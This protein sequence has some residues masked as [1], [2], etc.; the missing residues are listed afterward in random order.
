MGYGRAG[1]KMADALARAGVDVYDIQDSPLDDVPLSPGHVIDRAGTVGTPTGTR[2]KVTNVVCWLATP[3]HP[4]GWWEGQ[5]SVMFTMFETTKLPESFR[6]RLHEYDTVMV[7]SRQN[8]ELFSKFSDNVHYV[9]LGIDPDDWHYTPRPPA[10]DEFRFLVG[11]SGDRKGADVAFAAFKAV[12][13]N[14]Y[15]DGI[16][17]GTGPAPT[18]VMKQVTSMEGVYAPWVRLVSGRIPGDEERLLYE[19][20]HCYLGPARGEGFGLQPLQ[21]I[22]QGCPTILTNAHGQA[23]YAHLGIPIS[24]IET[25]A[26]YFAHGNVPGMNWWEPDLEELCEAM[27]DVYTNYDTHVARAGESAA[28]VARDWTWD[29]SAEQ[30]IAALDGALTRPAPEPGEWHTIS[31]KLYLVRVNRRWAADIGD[32]AYIFEPGQDYWEPGDV[33]RIMYESGL[34]EPSCLETMTEDG[35]DLDVGLTA[36]QV[37]KIGAYSAAN[38]YC[39][40]CQQQLNTRPT[41][42]DVIFDELE[43]VANAGALG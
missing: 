35:I 8:V 29:R 9:P 15:E 34:L 40:T 21:A 18:L 19:Q 36:E 31:P 5:H 7:P 2:S 3:G 28:V 11:G 1:V 4:R 16:W 23:D 22:A 14:H 41:R 42:A 30:F 37:T 10:S 32:K 43:A 6:D 38:A 27:W 26:G 33:K 13:G 12:F 20:A 17:R 24:A 25:E 39:P